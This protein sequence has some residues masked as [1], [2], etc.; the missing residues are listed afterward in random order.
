MKRPDWFKAA[1][2]ELRPDWLKLSPPVVFG[3]A[4]AGVVCLG[5]TVVYLP[6]LQTAPLSQ[7]IKGY[8]TSSNPDPEKLA[9]L[10]KGR[11]DSENAMRTG[12]I[13]GM[14]GTVLLVGLYFTYRNLKVAEDKQVTERFSKAVDMLSSASMHTRL[15]GIYALERIANDSDKDYGQV[16]EVLCAFVREESPWPPKNPDSV[17]EADR[18]EGIEQ[19]IDPRFN[20]SEQEQEQLKIHLRLPPLRTDIQA[21]M[22]VIGRRKHSYGESE[23]QDLHLHGT[24]LRRLQAPGANLTG[25]NL[26]RASLEG[27]IFPRAH[28]ED[29]SLYGA[30]LKG[31]MLYAAH[32]QGARM[33]EANLDWANLRGANLEKVRLLRTDLSQ[34][35]D[36]TQAQ[37]DSAITDEHTKLPDYLLAAPPSPQAPIAPP[38]PTAPEPNAEPRPPGT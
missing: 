35:P 9:T 21:V 3:L 5:W 13:Q 27:S 36:L 6:Q 2:P 32:L 22:T 4:V 17:V 8:E 7:K 12:L 18:L 10:E 20:F 31:A 37:L 29:S 38:S 28:L 33:E 15:G 26:S 25:V 11:I 16:M 30:N 24:D 19:S 34:V 1:I 23:T 14:G